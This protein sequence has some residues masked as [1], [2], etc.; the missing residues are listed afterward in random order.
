MADDKER[1][2]T[3]I[4]LNKNLK[5]L[6]K[7][8]E[9]FSNQEEIDIEKGFENVKEA[10]AIIK[11]SKQRIDTIKTS[12]EEIEREVQSVVGEEESDDAVDPDEIPF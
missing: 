6:E 1:E 4:D 5:R 3:D 12:F 7:I 2:T 10:A 11:E 9:W 8:S